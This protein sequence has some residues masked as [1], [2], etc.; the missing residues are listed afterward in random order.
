MDL[1]LFLQ[2]MPSEYLF[3]GI[4]IF[5]LIYS[6]SLP[7]TEEIALVLVGIL[8]HARDFPFPLVF[9]ASIPGIYGSDLL[10]FFVARKFG[11]KLLSSRLFRR[12]FKPG[13]ILASER[14]F[15]RHG[16]RITFFCRFFVGIRAPVMIAAGF[17]KMKFRRFALYDGLASIIATVFWLCAGYFFGNM[18]EKGLNSLV[19][20]FSIVG[21]VFVVSGAFFFTR[22]ISREERCMREAEDKATYQEEQTVLFG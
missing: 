13:K 19:F 12:L 16:P 20:I 18:L 4:F 1:P 7:I 21:P 8:S 10:Y 22:Q 9:A 6:F 11:L 17:L 14:C 15:R 2:N 5:L 3:G